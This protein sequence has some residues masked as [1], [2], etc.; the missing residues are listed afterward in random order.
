MGVR[1]KATEWYGAEIARDCGQAWV[2]NVGVRGIRSFTVEIVESLDSR[3]R[4]NDGGSGTCAL[5]MFR[6]PAIRFVGIE[7][8]A[9]TPSQLRRTPP[10]KKEAEGESLAT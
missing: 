1:S 3:V 7:I 10:A 8:V 5:L 6:H 9:S 2:V 4:G